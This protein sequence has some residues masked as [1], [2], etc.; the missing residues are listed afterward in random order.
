MEM[1]STLPSERDPKG[2]FTPV[3][4][5]SELKVQ[6]G[7]P[8]HRKARGAVRHGLS[9]RMHASVCVRVSSSGMQLPI[10]R[11]PCFLCRTY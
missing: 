7:S 3:N 6:V 10:T 1:E 11:S 8:S 4:L 5:A 2:T 9:L